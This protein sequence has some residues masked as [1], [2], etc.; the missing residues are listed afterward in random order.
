MWS[1]TH[2]RWIEIM[3]EIFTAFMG[4]DFLT[5]VYT[6]NL[7]CTVA[8]ERHPKLEYDDAVWDNIFKQ[9]MVERE[10]L[11]NE[12][13]RLGE[14]RNGH[15]RKKSGGDYLRPAKAEAIVLIL[16]CLLRPRRALPRS[17]CPTIVESVN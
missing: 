3:D 8:D 10:P 11:E 15:L 4:E 12:T 16:L 14:Q 6:E 1:A 5:Y 17:R 7:C 2:R 13:P 9:K